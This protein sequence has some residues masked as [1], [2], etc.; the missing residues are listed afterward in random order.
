MLGCS[1]IGNTTDFDSVI[2]GSIP[3]TSARVFRRGLSVAAAPEI[4]ILLVWV[5][6]P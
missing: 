6:L 3:D 1:V 4:V 2:S 5:Q